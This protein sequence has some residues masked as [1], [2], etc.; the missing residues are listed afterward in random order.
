MMKNYYIISSRHLM[1]F[2]KYYYIT[3]YCS[4]HLDVMKHIESHVIFPQ[5]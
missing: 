4:E 5:S 3:H 2:L 1:S